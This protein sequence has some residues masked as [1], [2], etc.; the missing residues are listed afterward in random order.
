M[1]KNT[2]EKLK[3]NDQEKCVGVLVQRNS[4]IDSELRANNRNQGYFAKQLFEVVVNGD[5]S[6]SQ[7]HQ[8]GSDWEKH[9]KSSALASDLA[10]WRASNRRPH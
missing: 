6:E 7:W 10:E 4:C 3:K 1:G 8:Q 9:R 5:Q 2:Q